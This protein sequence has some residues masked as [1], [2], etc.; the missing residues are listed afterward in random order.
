MF[1]P[2]SG[3][4]AFSPKENAVEYDHNSVEL[5]AYLRHPNQ[6]RPKD[7]AIG[8]LK[9]D[10]TQVVIFWGSAS[11]T[12][13]PFSLTHNK[14]SKVKHLGEVGNRLQVKLRKGY[15]YV[16]VPASQPYVHTPVSQPAPEPKQPAHS[17]ININ[18]EIPMTGE[19]WF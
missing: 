9:N 3:T 13:D 14:Q 7:W 11:L 19:S 16:R 5:T 2:V 8:M 1:S 17:Q 15:S 12:D 10:R 6:G 4:H 18:Q